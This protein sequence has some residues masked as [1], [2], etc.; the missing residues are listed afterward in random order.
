MAAYGYSQQERQRRRQDWERAAK[1]CP[2]CNA[3]INQQYK[4]YENDE[5]RRHCGADKCRAAAYRAAKAD[6]LY[7]AREEATASITCYAAGLPAEQAAAF[8]TMRMV[9]MNELKPDLQNGHVQALAVLNVIESQRCKHDRI[10]ALKDNADAEKRRAAKAEEYAQELEALY[11]RRIEELQEEIRAYQTLEHAIHHIAT[12]QLR[13]QPD[14]PA[15][16]ATPEPEGE[17]PDRAHTLLVLRQLGMK[18]ISSMSRAELEARADGREFT[19]EEDL[20]EE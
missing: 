8:K 9:L 14:P 7:K 11:K 6:R 5:A 19:E 13:K 16:Q 17:D 2:H 18:P 4:E 12:E 10:Q 3:P 15:Q 1:Q 20:D